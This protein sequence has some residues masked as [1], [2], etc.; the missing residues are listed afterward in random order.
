MTEIRRVSAR[1]ALA[2]ISVEVV[3]GEAAVPAF[4]DEREL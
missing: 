4:D 1:A 3:G 2:E